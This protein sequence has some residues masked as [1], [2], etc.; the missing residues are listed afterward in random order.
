MIKAI[1]IEDEELVA[2]R[3]QRMIQEIDETIVV[4]KI[5]SS[6][7]ESITYLTHTTPDLIFL[8]INLSDAYSFEI[9][10]VLEITSPIIFTTAYSEYAIKA[11]DQNSIAYLLKPIRKHELEKALEKHLKLKTASTTNDSLHVKAAIQTMYKKRFLTK[12]NHELKII[13]VKDVAY[14]YSE[15]RLTFLMTKHKT[16]VI[17][18]DTLKNLETILNPNDFFRINRK[19]MI[20]TDAIANMYYTSKSRIRIQLSPT[21]APEHTIVAIERMSA[22]K[23]WLAL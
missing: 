17:I 16:R 6:V 7:A 23:K 19:Y 2:I 3:L 8:D 1:I 10:E 18:N 9:F 11:F 22:F 13:D 15:D 12:M 21:N 4:S 20:S 14:I 5:L